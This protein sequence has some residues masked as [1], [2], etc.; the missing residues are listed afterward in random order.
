MSSLILSP[1]YLYDV[2]VSS[3]SYLYLVYGRYLPT[4]VPFFWWMDQQYADEFWH[5]ARVGVWQGLDPPIV[6]RSRGLVLYRGLHL[7]TL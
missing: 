7:E 3:K 6:I 4:L 5:F 2:Y 1:D